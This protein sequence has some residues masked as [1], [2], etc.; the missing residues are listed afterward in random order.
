MS[1]TELSE[2]VD[3]TMSNLSIPKRAKPKQFG[4]QPWRLSAANWNASPAIFWNTKHNNFYEKAGFDQNL[5]WLKP[6]AN[7][8][9][10]ILFS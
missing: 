8:L 3:M 5:F 6:A 2:R 7:I 10:R 9:N 1:L 4:F